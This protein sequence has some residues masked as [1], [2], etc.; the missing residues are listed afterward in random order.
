MSY[1]LSDPAFL[2]NPAPLL[3]Q[4][5]AEGPLVRIRLPIMGT[6]WAT[7]TDA[8][9]RQLLKS[10][11]LFRRDPA[12]VTGTSIAQRFWWMPAS[13]KPLLGTMIVQDDPD[14]RRLRHLV[15]L[16]FARATIED[17][18]PRI[19]AM[20]E[21]LLDD[22]PRQGPVDIVARYTRPL[23]FLAICALLGIPEDRHA[24]LTARIAPISHATNPLRALHA[25]LRLRGLQ[26]SLRALFADARRA[27]QG[28]GL[29]SALVHAEEDGARLT[30]EELLSMVMLLFLAGH[31]TTVHLINNGIAAIAR[32]RALRAHLHGH[33]LLIEELVRYFSPVMLTKPMVAVRDTDALGA[34]VRKGEMV[35]AFLLAANHDPARVDAPH[36]LM[37]ERLPNAHLGFGFGPHACLGMQLARIEAQVALDRLFTR[38]PRLTLASPPRWLKRPGFRAPATLSLTLG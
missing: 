16:A 9:A 23:P 38:H 31:E 30:G 35:S 17:M 19:E 14:H 24:D 21:R 6:M 8:A 10:P 34:M 13:I 37:P 32:N 2:E 18:R 4:M 28:P 29:I 25:V 33:P 3:A 11:D 15:E 20:A 1:R 22:L 26:D 36:L 27:P 5:R 12:P 7:T